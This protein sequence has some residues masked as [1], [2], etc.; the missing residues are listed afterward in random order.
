MDLKP[1][2]TFKKRT[3]DCTGLIMGDYLWLNFS[4]ETHQFKQMHF[5]CIWKLQPGYIYQK[6]LTC[7]TGNHVRRDPWKTIKAMFPFKPGERT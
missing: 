2:D 7:F 1:V 4:G 6:I 3:K 5:G